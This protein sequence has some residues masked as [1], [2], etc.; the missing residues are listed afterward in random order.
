M[1]SMRNK[2]KGV[3]GLC[4]ETVLPRMGRWRLIPKQTQDFLGLRC[5]KCSTTTRAN[6][7]YLAQIKIANEK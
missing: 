5:K 4:K 6:K 1:K 3:C 7:K 2:Y